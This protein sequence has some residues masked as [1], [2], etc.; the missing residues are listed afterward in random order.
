M[1]CR[2]IAADIIIIKDN[3]ILLVKRGYEPFKGMW[4]LPGGKLEDNE[5]IEQCAIR[6]V[7]EEIN[8]DIVI[9]KLV[10]IYSDPNRD[11]RKIV[12]V[13]FLC[14]IKKGEIKAGDDVTEA[15]WFDLYEVESIKLASDHNNIIR[16]ALKLI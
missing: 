6:E 5:S 10:G 15:K 9:K 16:D 1:I 12:A 4:A 14:D 7:K 11:P 8:V 3:K 2:R 13:A